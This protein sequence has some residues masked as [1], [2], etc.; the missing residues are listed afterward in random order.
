MDS[1]GIWHPLG[2][3]KQDGQGNAATTEDEEHWFLLRLKCR[4]N[5]A[6]HGNDRGCRR[7]T[8][9]ARARG[10]IRSRCLFSL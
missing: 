3:V 10:E 4:T 5:E 1:V 9:L 2:L 8:E 7:E 6:L